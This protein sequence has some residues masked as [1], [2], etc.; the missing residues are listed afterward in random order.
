MRWNLIRHMAVLWT[1]FFIIWLVPKDARGYT[2]ILGIKELNDELT[3][4]GV[5]D[6]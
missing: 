5:R 6:V 3:R 4:I 2:I 1:F